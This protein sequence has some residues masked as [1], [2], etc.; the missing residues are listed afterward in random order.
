MNSDCVSRAN[1]S[2]RLFPSTTLFRSGAPIYRTASSSAAWVSLE[3][4]SGCGE[5]GW[6]WQDN[7]YGSR[8]DLGPSIYFAA[9]GPQTIRVQIREDGLSVDQIVLSAG[10]YSKSAPGAAKNDAT[11]LKQTIQP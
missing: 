5:Q 11:I 3:E 10:T 4:C 2:V 1:P 9:S 8:G 7:A 6:G